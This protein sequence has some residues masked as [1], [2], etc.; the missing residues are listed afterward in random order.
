MKMSV[1]L[2]VLVL[3]TPGGVTARDLTNGTSFVSLQDLMQFTEKIEDTATDLGFEANAT[4]PV[5]L[6][7]FTA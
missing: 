1:V 3:T 5:R 4:L 7:G 2:T 6:G